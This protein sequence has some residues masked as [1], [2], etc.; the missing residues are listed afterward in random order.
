MN[1]DDTNTA[2]WRLNKILKNLDK[3]SGS[4]G[5]S[6]IT[7]IV[8]VKYQLPRLSKLITDEL[9]KAS[10]IKS[11][12]TRQA[13]EQVLRSIQSRIKLIRSVPVN[14]L[15]IFCGVISD[16]KM[17]HLIEPL[18]PLKQFM[19]RCDNVFHTQPLKDQ[20]MT[21]TKYGFLIVDGNG[22]LGAL[23][24]GNQIKTLFEYSM[25]LPNKQKAGGQSAPR[26]ERIRRQLY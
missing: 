14:G 12:V 8:P 25:H 24:Q 7:L 23:V 16:R 20:L 1:N 10:C 21:K 6:L 3:V 15:V 19:Y 22:A 2:S 18:L 4:S 9:G 11:R 26:F 13:V 17:F 5:S